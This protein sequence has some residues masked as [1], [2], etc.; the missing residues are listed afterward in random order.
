MAFKDYALG[1]LQGGLPQ[2]LDDPSKRQTT[3]QGD[4]KPERTPPAAKITDAEPALIAKMRADP[5]QAAI[6]IGGGI[7]LLVV[8]VYLIKRV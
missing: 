7:V 8:V 6:Y 4:N 3:A 1:I 2:V 5:M